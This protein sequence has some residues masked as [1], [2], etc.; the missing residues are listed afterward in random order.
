MVFG[1]SRLPLAGARRFGRTL[2]HLGTLL[3]PNSLRCIEDQLEYS[4]GSTRSEATR[5]R[6]ARSVLPD[7]GEQLCEFLVQSRW[8]LDRLLASIELTGLDQL[9]RAVVQGIERGKGLI[10]IGGHFGSW[11]LSAALLNHLTPGDL[12]CVARR[13]D[14]E[15]YQ[16]ILESLRR[17][18]GTRMIYQE[19]SLLPILRVLRRGGCL[20]LLPDQDF[21]QLHEGIFVNFLGRPAYT[22][23]T[24]AELALRTGAA[25]LVLTCHREGPRMV[26]KSSP[27]VSAED[28]SAD[29]NPV[30]SITRWWSGEIEKRIRERPSQW[31]WLHRRWRTTPDRLEYRAL[32]RQERERKRRRETP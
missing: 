9:S 14:H 8:G 18:F 25:M 21:K 24:P 20:G 4:F 16:K 28:F 23:T 3:S 15:G 31:V 32:R 10:A 27:L 2:G 1:V 5:R 17:G 6:I 29:P 13:Y 7:L 11:E 26:V 22:T 30:A 12:Y 19:D